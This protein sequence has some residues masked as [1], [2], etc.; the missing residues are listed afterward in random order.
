MDRNGP[1]CALRHGNPLLAEFNQSLKRVDS[2]QGRSGK[3][4]LWTRGQLFG[5]AETGTSGHF[6]AVIING[7]SVVVYDGVKD[8]ELHST[9][10]LLSLGNCLWFR[11][12]AI[13][14]DDMRARIL[15]NRTQALSRRQRRLNESQHRPDSQLPS[16][17]TLEQRAM[18]SSSR[19]AALS[20][21]CRQLV[22]PLPPIGWEHPLV[23]PTPS[24]FLTMN[25]HL[26]EVGWLG[27]LNEH[28]RDHRLTFVSETHRYFID[29]VQTLGSVIGL[30]HSVCQPF[31]R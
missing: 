19:A 27:Q 28:V 9:D 31:R 1:L 6:H 15:S 18:H 2:I 29:G 30:L 5:A 4:I 24:D 14:A 7:S 12:E 13:I 17:W 25:T 20:R 3:Y 26:P 16:S 21:R 22:R 10:S 23:I 11:L 8:Y